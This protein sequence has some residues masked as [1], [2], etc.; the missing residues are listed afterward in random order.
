M[1]ARLRYLKRIDITN[2]H[3]DLCC[4]VGLNLT[5]VGLSKSKNKNDEIK[6]CGNVCGAFCVWCCQIRAIP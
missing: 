3:G 4:H 2:P 5:A 6:V 1:F